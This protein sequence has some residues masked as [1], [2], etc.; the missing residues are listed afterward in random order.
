MS[1]WGTRTGQNGRDELKGDRQDHQAAT[2]ESADQ[3]IKRILR[4]RVPNGKDHVF[5]ASK[6][7]DLNS[8][9]VYVIST[10][11]KHPGMA[12]G[13]LPVIQ[14]LNSLGLKGTDDYC[15]IDETNG[16]VTVTVNAAALEAKLPALKKSGAAVDPV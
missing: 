4:A 15:V 5:G 8:R 12:L 13:N 7:R 9:A 14:M 16:N 6:G 2:A 1:N 10:S 11:K 3:A